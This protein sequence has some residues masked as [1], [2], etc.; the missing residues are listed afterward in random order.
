MKVTDTATIIARIRAVRAQHLDRAQHADAARA[1]LDAAKAQIG[2][3]RHEQA[4]SSVGR[5]VEIATTEDDK[6]DSLRLEGASG[7]G[8]RRSFEESALPRGGRGADRQ[9]LRCPQ[10]LGLLSGRG[11]CLAPE[12]RME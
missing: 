1:Y 2:A 8:Q 9:G 4:L 7:S 3:Y 5:A 6:Y 11:R 10:L 12:P